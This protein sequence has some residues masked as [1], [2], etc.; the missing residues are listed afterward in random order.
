MLNRKIFISLY[1]ISALSLIFYSFVLFP[2][3]YVGTTKKNG[4]TLGCVCHSVNPTTGVNVSIIGPDSVAAGQTAL[5]RVKI[6]G[7]P[8][9]I[10]GFNVA[11]YRD[12]GSDTLSLTAVPGDTLIRK[13]DGE[14]THR[15]PTLFSSDTVSWVFRYTA[16]FTIGYDTLF[17]TGNSCNNDSLSDNDQWN[18]SPNKVVRIYNPIGIINISSVAKDFSLWQNYPNPFNPVTNIKFSVKNSSFVTINIYDITGKVVA[19]PVNQNLKSGEYKLEFDASNLP[20]GI[21]LY[22][23]SANGNLISTKK[24]LVVK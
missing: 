12:S 11:N 23:M 8:A 19:V 3:G 5:F 9:A 1:I 15:R 10:G 24:M 20:S 4:G 2:T 22:S 14:L 17:A 21:Y 16:N 18:W 7:G 13:Q 6:Q